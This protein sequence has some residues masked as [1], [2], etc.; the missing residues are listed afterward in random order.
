MNRGAIFI[1]PYGYGTAVKIVCLEET[2]E[3]DPDIHLTMSH[4]VVLDKVMLE[5]N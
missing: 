3:N 4:Q 5:I 1:H 2:F